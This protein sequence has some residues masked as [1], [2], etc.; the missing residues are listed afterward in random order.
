MEGASAAVVALVLAASPGSICRPA[1]TD[2]ATRPIPPQLAP[3]VIAAF[4]VRMTPAYVVDTG[5]IRCADG[6]LLACLVGANLNCGKADTR[7][8]NPGA[9]NWCR[10]HP[11]SDFVPA[12]ATG[13]DTIY[14]W[15][16]E[17][18]RAVVERQVEH[19]D[20]QGFVAEN[21]KQV[22]D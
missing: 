15:R 17:G 6:H 14:A 11:S 12:F 22:G 4:G 7:T 2:A 8:T 20:R 19:V 21:W 5:V 1:E 18:Q 10:D 13:H 3:A 16:C 9:S